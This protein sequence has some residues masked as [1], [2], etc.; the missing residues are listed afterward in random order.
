[1]QWKW[2]CTSSLIRRSFGN[3]GFTSNIPWKLRQ[4]CKH[5]YLF[6]SCKECIFCNL[7]GWR[8]MSRSRMRRTLM[9]D[10]P[11]A[12]P[13]SL[14]GCLGL[15]PMDA[16]SRALLSGVRTED[17]RPGC[18]FTRDSLLHATALSID[19]LLLEMGLPVD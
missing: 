14:A 10:M 7:C 15:R 13:C 4:N 17:G 6:R 19:G 18:L 11:A 9:S 2:K 16:K 5:T 12:G 3:S 1:V 8:F